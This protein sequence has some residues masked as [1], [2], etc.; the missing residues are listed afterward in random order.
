MSDVI[1]VLATFLIGFVLGCLAADAALRKKTGFG[2][3]EHLLEEKT[4]QHH[5]GIASVAPAK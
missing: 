5:G 4:K 3:Q 1:Y 2:I